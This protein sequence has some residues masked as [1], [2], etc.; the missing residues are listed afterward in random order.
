MR[1]AVCTTTV[2]LESNDVEC[3][4]CGVRM[5]SH[6]G[7]GG[8]VRY[9]HCASCQRWTSSMYADVLRAD[10]KMR[11]RSPLPATGASTSTAFGEVKTRLENWLKSLEVRS[12]WQVLG[13]TPHDSDAAVRERYLALARQHH[14]DRGGRVEDMRRVNEAYEAVVAQRARRLAVVV[15]TALPTGA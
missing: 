9:F 7:S 14:P 6:V 13:C 15:P 12:P 4:H 5:S 2:S 1:S 11:A 8:Q 10:S 3:T